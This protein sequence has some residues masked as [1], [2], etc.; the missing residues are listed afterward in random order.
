MTEV[1]RVP[2]MHTERIVLMV[3]IA[4]EMRRSPRPRKCRE[5]GFKRVLVSIAVF[6][7][8]LYAGTSLARCL[9]CWGVRS[10]GA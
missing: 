6:N 9:E 2:S 1:Y 3:G 4:V 8:D 5:C 7:D 10:H